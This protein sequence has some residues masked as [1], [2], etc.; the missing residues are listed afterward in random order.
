MINADYIIAGS[1][2]ALVILVAIIMLIKSGQASRS[3]LDSIKLTTIAGQVILV[4]FG[5]LVLAAAASW[6][7]LISD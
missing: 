3:D 2:L 6:W 5:L 1:I 4:A 7:A